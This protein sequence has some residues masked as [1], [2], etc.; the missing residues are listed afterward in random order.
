MLHHYEKILYPER[1][2]LEGKEITI[3][4]IFPDALYTNK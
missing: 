1:K 2:D 4:T 3:S